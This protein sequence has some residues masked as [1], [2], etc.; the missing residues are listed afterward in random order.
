LIK[1]VTKVEL[2]YICYKTNPSQLEITLKSISGSQRSASL[3]SETLG[4]QQ[5]L[6]FLPFSAFHYYTGFAI[7]VSNNE[8]NAFDWRFAMVQYM[9]L[10]FSECLNPV[11]YNL[12]S[13]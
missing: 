6:L 10:R 13:M 11:F 1:Y 4:T 5:F 3:K 12:S 8:T 7:E 9:M 2:D